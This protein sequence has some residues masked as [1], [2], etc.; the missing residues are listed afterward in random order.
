MCIL[1]RSREETGGVRA[2]WAGPCEEGGL[3]ATALS[4]PDEHFSELT[5][6]KG[7][8]LLQ[9][10]FKHGRVRTQP[11]CYEKR[12]LHSCSAVFLWGMKLMN[13]LKKKK[14]KV[15][16]GALFC[17]LLGTLLGGRLVALWSASL[18]MKWKLC[19][20]LSSNHSACNMCFTFRW[21][22]SQFECI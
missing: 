14:E 15:C 1:L 13:S 8:V 16:M 22:T 19:T 9:L 5:G 6:Q 7:G 12:R 3:R 4:S 2:D 20:C 17:L 21:C 10:G 18:F 11:P